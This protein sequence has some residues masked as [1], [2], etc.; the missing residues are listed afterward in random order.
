MTSWLNVLKKIKI[1]RY[2]LGYHPLEEK[3]DEYL[4]Y[5]LGGLRPC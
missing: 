4:I 3:K 1:K 2:L 5:F